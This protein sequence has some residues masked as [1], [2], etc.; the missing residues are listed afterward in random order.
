VWTSPI[1]EGFLNDVRSLNV[2]LPSEKRVRVVLGDP[3]I[4]WSVVRGPADED[5][6]DW[7]D[8][9]FAWV[10][11][12]QVLKKGRRALLWIRGAH[13]GRKVRFPDSLI[14][15]LDQR[16]PNQTMVALS[17][18][19]QDLD[20][21]IVTRLGGWPAGRAA[22]VRNTT[23]GRLDAHAVGLRLST[24]TVEQNL[25]GAVF[26]TTSRPDEGPRIDPES[27]MALEL[28]RRQQLSHATTA[29]RGGKIRF[30]AEAAV[31]LL[32]S[33]PA[34][35]TVL[36]EL[37]RE[38]SLTLLVKAFAD[39]RET[40][41]LQLSWQRARAVVEWLVSHGIASDRLE[42]LGCGSSRAL[43]V[44][45]TEE[46]R[47]ANRKAELVRISQWEQCEPPTSFNFK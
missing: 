21:P 25:D 30:A 47:A 35:R 18:D 42:P 4:D 36:A 20:E 34:L 39:A 19:H 5:M 7:R 14:H 43:W 31:I 12:E 1:Y 8:A 32:A 46:E 15:L 29:F 2:M 45:D 16:F 24:G 17:L 13:L 9:H 3:P 38:A 44:G 22:S 26:W 6:N 28:L 37:Q 33:E 40:D 23:L 41:G 11:E 27:P 10:T